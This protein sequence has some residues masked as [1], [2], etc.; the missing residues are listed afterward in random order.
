MREGLRCKKSK[1]FFF[2][3]PPL[4]SN[5]WE[6]GVSDHA[7]G[8]AVLCFMLYVLF[9]LFSFA[10]H[11]PV[12]LRFGW[13]WW[14]LVGALGNSSIHFSFVGRNVFLSKAP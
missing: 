10:P 7:M 13:W 5:R 2:S 3:F 14:W 11:S 12:S 9:L 8:W 1:F 6:V 4:L